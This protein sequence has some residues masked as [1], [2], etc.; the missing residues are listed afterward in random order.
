MV[1]S[2]IQQYPTQAYAGMRV[3]MDDGHDI[4]TYINNAGSVPGVTDIV[5]TAVND[6]VYSY[7]AYGI[8]VSYTADGSATVAEVRLGLIAAHN[9]IPLLAS[10]V[11]AVTSGANIRLTEL[12]TA[13]GDMAVAEADADLALSV[14]TAHSAV[15]AWPAG[16]VVARG[17]NFQDGRLPTTNADPL[18][19]CVIHQH[20]NINERT[21]PAP[22]RVVYP[23]S[24]EVPVLKRGKVWC[25]T[26]EAV[27]LT[28]TPFMRFASGS[29]GT[30]L[31][32]IR[33]SADTATAVTLSG[34]AKFM[35][36]QANAGG[37]VLVQF[38]FVP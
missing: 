36:P 31:G 13:N 14:V 16:I 19:G 25:V 17:P 26:E 23:P 6:H 24:S 2:A 38:N 3:G 37:L 35:T 4:E 30:Q 20:A 29:G 15:Q 28:D 22:S 9:A 27:A 11:S 12:N 33:K 5:I 1:L 32:A 7:S 18:V 34:K 21:Y 8:T 10:M